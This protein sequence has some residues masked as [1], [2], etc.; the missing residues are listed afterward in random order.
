MRATA[1]RSVLPALIVG[2][3]VPALLVAVAGAQAPSARTVLTVHWS[4]ED[5]PTTPLLDEAIRRTVLSGSD[6]PVDYFAEYLESDRFAPEDASAALADYIRRKY[7]GRHID[8]VVAVSDPSLEFVERY[9]AELFPDAPIVASMSTLPDPRRRE[10]GA[11]I[12]GILGGVAYDKTLD[13]A[14]QLHPATRRVF[15]VAYSPNSRLADRV[16]TALRDVS[17]RVPLTYLEEPSVAGLLA[18]VRAVPA[19]SLILFI[20]HSQ[21]DRGAVLFPN[22]VAQMVSQAAPVPVYGIS[23]LY[24]GTGIVGGVVTSRERLGTRLGQM[25]RQLLAG[26]Q[27]TG[28]PIE[29]VPHVPTFDWRQIRRW[30]IDEAALPPDA[31]IRFRQPGAWELYRGYII[32]AIALLL[33]QSS[34]IGALLVQRSRRRRV[35]AALR[36]SEAHFRVTAD[37]AP[38]M[39]W[40]S[41]ADRTCDFF[42]LPW[43]AFTGRSLE[44][45]LGDGWTGSVH[46][47]DLATCLAT[48]R[49]AFDAREPFRMEFRM[50]RF[51]GEYRWVLDTGIPRREPDGRFAGYIGS[52]LD[53]TDRLLAETAL[54]EAQDELRRKSRLSALGEFAA[55][56]AHEIR[57]PLTAIIMNARS[58][59]RGIGGGEPDLEE[60]KAGLLDVVEASQRAEEVIQRNRRLFR[61]KT[62][63]VVPLDINAVIRE[64]VVLAAARLR[65]SQVTLI[66]ALADDLPAVS[67][68]RIELQQVL[69]NL[70][71]NAVDALDAVAAGSRRVEVSSS[72][73]EDQSVVVAVADNGVGL[74]HVDVRRMFTL[75]YTTK[76]KGTGVGLSISRSIIDAH[77]GRLWA[78]Q[79]PSGGAIFR[80]TVPVRTPVDLERPAQREQSVSQI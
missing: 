6:T 47:D 67:G 12:T 76:A 75:A 19:D 51:D 37:T 74:A 38:V 28:I 24:L 34:L 2:F 15:V 25:T 59:L 50:R 5:F 44:Q 40:R 65:D 29:P 78:E 56:I 36:E 52:R 70:I 7:R 54:Q 21:E 72:L 45:E 61:D 14:L 27:A 79:N 69:L 32:G 41:G 11:G 46:P 20:R 26:A 4:A 9:R 63:E 8:A 1:A 77:R 10:S 23:D 33:V 22:E 55:S 3:V 57:Q 35:E 13:L 58:C 62:V 42:N 73:A 80:F 49:A 30:R 60:L 53:I 18:A 17:D 64:T 66:T 71:D 39:I 16:H 48:Y 43:L 31:T 68:D